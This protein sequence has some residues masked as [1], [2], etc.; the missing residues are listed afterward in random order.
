MEQ[1]LLPDWVVRRDIRALLA[2]RLAEL[3]RDCES[4]AAYKLAFIG[5]MDAAPIALVPDRANEQ[6]YEVPADFF[7]AVL[8]PR[9]K[10]SACWWPE[11]V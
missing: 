6:H 8:G 3:P 1:G 11:E 7:A 2:Q 5:R 4:A 10:Y 9:R